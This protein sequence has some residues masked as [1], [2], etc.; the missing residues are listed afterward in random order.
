MYLSQVDDLIHEAVTAACRVLDQ[1]FP[2][3]D[4]DGINSNIAG[5]IQECI[6]KQLI[7]YGLVD[8]E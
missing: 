1:Q 7:K 4:R 6:E 8:E 2:G 3:G 5:A